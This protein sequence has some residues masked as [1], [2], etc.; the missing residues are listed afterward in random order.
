MTGDSCT[1]FPPQPQ[2][3]DWWIMNTDG[4]NKTRLTYMNKKGNAQCDNHYRLAGTISFMRNNCFL[5]GV[6]TKALGLVGYTAKVVFYYPE[7]KM[8]S[9]ERYSEVIHK[10]DS[11]FNREK[12]HEAILFYKDADS[13]K[14][15]EEYPKSQWAACVQ[16]I[17]AQNEDPPYKTNDQ[18]YSDAIKRADQ[19][20]CAKRFAEAKAAYQEALAIKPAEQY[21]KDQVKQCDKY[22]PK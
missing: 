22:L 5:G 3:S 8:I 10:A 16:K 6:M 12:Y 11:C 14:P 2:G 9:Q 13:L 20:F 18:K 21:P 4:S 7:E 1:I 19:L 15:N 17:A